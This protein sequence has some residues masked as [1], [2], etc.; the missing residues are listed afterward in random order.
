MKHI[1][2]L[3]LALFVVNPLFSQCADPSNIFTFQYDGKVYEIVKELNSW[4]AAAACAVERGGYLVEINSAEE[5]DTLFS[6]I[7]NGAM[8][9]P[10]YTSIANG[11]GIAYL[12]IGANDVMREGSWVWDGDNDEIGSN[13][14]EGEGSNGAGDGVPI[15]AAYNNWGGSST[16][17]PKEPDNFGSGQHHAAI[18][19]TGW[20]VG[21][22]MLGIAGEWNDILG[23]SQLYYVIEKDNEVGIQNFG[24]EQP[25]LI[26]P[27]PSNGVLN[28]SNSYEF[29][30]IYSSTGKLMKQYQN[31]RTIDISSLQKGVYF[32]RIRNH[33]IILMGKF[34]YN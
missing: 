29:V 1:I 5:Q 6:A 19:L 14:W 9:S 28:F 32:I 17:A 23:S 12:W 31:S 15:D 3:I 16:G 25:F 33:S 26:Y 20:P 10:T 8:V 11:G 30:E 2:I 7:I 21:T 13:F 34:I 4:E 27:N 22:T 24:S 18:A